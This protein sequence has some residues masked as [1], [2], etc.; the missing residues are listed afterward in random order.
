ML[1]SDGS[2]RYSKATAAEAL[3]RARRSDVMVYPIAIGGTRTE[4]FAQLA[5]LTGGRS[6]QPRTPADLDAHHAD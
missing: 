6:F 5:T 4:L 2:D 1:L 3:D